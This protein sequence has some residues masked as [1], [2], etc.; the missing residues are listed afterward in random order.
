MGSDFKKTVTRPLPLAP[1]II[2]RKGVRLAAYFGLEL[3]R[4]KA[5]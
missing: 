3:Q 5:K 1:E 4:K 2:E